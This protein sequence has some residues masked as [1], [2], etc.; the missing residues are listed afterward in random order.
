[1]AFLIVSNL[2]FLWNPSAPDARTS[3]QR[4]DSEANRT[5][6]VGHDQGVNDA[7]R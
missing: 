4:L 5:P 1:M 2:S 6:Y 7:K 3:G